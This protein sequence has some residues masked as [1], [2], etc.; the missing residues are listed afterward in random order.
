MCIVVQ[1][2][3]TLPVS[4]VKKSLGSE[5]SY[6][7]WDLGDLFIFESRKLL[8]SFFQLWTSEWTYDSFNQNP[9]GNNSSFAKKHRKFQPWNRTKPRFTEVLK[10]TKSEGEKSFSISSSEHCVTDYLWISALLEMGLRCGF[11]SPRR[12]GCWWDVQQLA[13]YFDFCFCSSWCQVLNTAWSRFAG[14]TRN[15]VIS[16]LNLPVRED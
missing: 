11:E 15:Q 7:S 14:E 3:A 12:K 5:S 2:S 16:K 13:G 8:L 6:F 10:T 4:L 1:H 9:A